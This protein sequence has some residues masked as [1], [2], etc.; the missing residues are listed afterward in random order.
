MAAKYT[1]CREEI[2]SVE[3]PAAHFGYSGAMAVPM[4][5][6]LS[7]LLTCVALVVGSIGGTA[8]LVVATGKSPFA[9][10]FGLLVAP[11]LLVAA[12]FALAAGRRSTFAVALALVVGIVATLARFRAGVDPTA[13]YAPAA[14]VTVLLCIVVL[15]L[16][17][18]AGQKTVAW[19]GVVT[20]A[21]ALPIWL[22]LAIALAWWRPSQPP[23]YGVEGGAEWAIF[24]I[25]FLLVFVLLAAISATLAAL[26]FPV[27]D[28]D[29]AN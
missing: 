19:T 1:G 15:L 29:R 9:V 4:S 28:V 18:F 12:P 25:A 26:R 16:A 27:L 11:N 13:V 14:L 10:G 6:L 24:L 21:L 2:L 7:R 3:Q 17:R 22:G 23:P 20:A 5:R 8:L